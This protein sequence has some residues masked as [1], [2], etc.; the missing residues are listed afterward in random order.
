V[1]TPALPLTATTQ[2]RRPVIVWLVRNFSNREPRTCRSATCRDDQGPIVAEV[3]YAGGRCWRICVG[4]GRLGAAASGTGENAPDQ[5][6]QGPH[7][8]AAAGTVEHP[9]D[10]GPFQQGQSQPADYLPGAA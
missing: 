6:P 3:R 1:T 4:S 5:D 7:G 2:R 9:L 8:W 10:L